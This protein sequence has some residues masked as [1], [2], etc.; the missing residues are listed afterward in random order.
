M[1]AAREH[2]KHL[3]KVLTIKYVEVSSIAKSTAP[4][5]APKVTTVPAQIAAD[6]IYSLA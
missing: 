5:G 3:T 1:I 2:K 6:N 4:I